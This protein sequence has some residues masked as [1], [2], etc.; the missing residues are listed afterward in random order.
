MLVSILAPQTTLSRVAVESSR[1]QMEPML[2]QATL[3]LL[4]V[5]ML[6]QV[7]TLRPLL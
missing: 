7:S 4:Q 6:A 1:L 2:S 3:M 5:D